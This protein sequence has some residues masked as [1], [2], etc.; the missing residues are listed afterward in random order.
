[1]TDAGA[2]AVTAGDPPE[3]EPPEAEPPG[4]FDEYELVLL[5]SPPDRAELDDEAGER[6]Q[7]QHLGHL[8]AMHAAGHLLAAGPLRD[9]PDP[10]LRGLC[11]YRAGSVAAAMELAS[12][13]P[14]VRAGQLE[15]EAMTW[16][17]R[18][19]ALAFGG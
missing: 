16:R 9:Q 2:G 17:T 11:I 14:A 8:A 19:G 3:A 18:P 13:D 7:R 10:R 15:A 12:S 6:I 1:M 5:W 4:R